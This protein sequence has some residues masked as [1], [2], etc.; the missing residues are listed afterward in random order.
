[1]LYP[2]LIDVFSKAYHHLLQL[3]YIRDDLYFLMTQWI[4]E[5]ILDS[6][7]HFVPIGGVLID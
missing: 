3:L 5:I 4:R 6:G 1:M 2:I 7:N